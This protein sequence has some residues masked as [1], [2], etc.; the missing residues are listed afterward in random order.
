MTGSLYIE[1]EAEA[2]LEQAADR[3]EEIVPGW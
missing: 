2:E 1:P 3:Y